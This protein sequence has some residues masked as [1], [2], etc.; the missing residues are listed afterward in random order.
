MY[1]EL[2]SASPSYGRSYISCKRSEVAQIGRMGLPEIG[3]R[4]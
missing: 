3:R 2:Y 4:G 1:S